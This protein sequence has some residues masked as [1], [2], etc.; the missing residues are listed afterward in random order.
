MSPTLIVIAA[1]LFALLIYDTWVMLKK[2]YHWTISYTLR[3]LAS[4]FPIVACGIGIVIGHLFWAHPG[5]C[6]Q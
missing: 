6:G 3:D 5:D 1:V 2:G 4:R